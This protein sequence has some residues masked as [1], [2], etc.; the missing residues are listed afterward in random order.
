VLLGDV[1]AERE[2]CAKLCDEIG[3]TITAQAIREGA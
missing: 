3:A 1:L 2:R